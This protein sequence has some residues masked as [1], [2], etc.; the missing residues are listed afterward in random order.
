MNGLHATALT[1]LLM[2]GTCSC[3]GDDVVDGTLVVDWTVEGS[4]AP[5]ACRDTGADAISVV[6]VS[7]QGRG[8][9]ELVEL[10]ESFEARLALAPGSYF[11][12]ATLVGADG[13]A[14]TT[15]V[16]DRPYVYS[17]DLTVSAFDFPTDSFY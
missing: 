3:S 15:T 16:T 5:S 2:L 12:E 1:L 10:C 17:A 7:G 14:L 6:I 9:V 4:K 13:A 8:A 11:I